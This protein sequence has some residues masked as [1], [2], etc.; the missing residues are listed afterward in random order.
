MARSKTR[1]KKETDNAEETPREDDK[2]SESPPKDNRAPSARAPSS[3]AKQPSTVSSVQEVPDRTPKITIQHF[4]R[5]T[6]DPILLAFAAHEKLTQ[7]TRKL[8]K[9]E[10]GEEYAAF[11]GASR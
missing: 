11:R 9:A 3:A 8:T 1:I 7:G 4:V 10:W 6:K 2:P 5:G